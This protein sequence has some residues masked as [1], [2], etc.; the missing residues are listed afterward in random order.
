MTWKTITPKL[1]ILFLILKNIEYDFV[2]GHRMPQN[3]NVYILDWK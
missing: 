3:S 2:Y 1:T